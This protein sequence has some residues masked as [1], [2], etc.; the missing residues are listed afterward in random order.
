MFTILIDCLLS[1]CATENDTCKIVHV[2][3]KFM[4]ELFAC[5]VIFHAFVVCRLFSK[6]TID[7]VRRSKFDMLTSE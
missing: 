2:I 1:K 6:F 3:T 4:F 5:L 7:N